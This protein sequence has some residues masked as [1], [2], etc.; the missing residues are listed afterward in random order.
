MTMRQA[1]NFKYI[2]TL[3]SLVIALNVVPAAA[4][5]NKKAKKP[6]T[7]AVVKKNTAKAP[8][9]QVVKPTAT[10]QKAS[11][12]NLGEAAA[13][14]A[15]DTAK[16]NANANNPGNLSEEIVVTTAYKPV[17]AD[18][19]KIRLN[20]DL[21]DKTPFK[22]PLTYFPI[23]KRLELNSG[24]K[25]LE[26]MKRPSERDTDI[27][28]NYIKAG[29]GNLKTTYAE[30]Y[31]ANSHDEALQVGGFLKHFAQNGTL[32]NQN[33]Q[34]DAVGAYIKTIGKDVS[35]T[36]RLNYNYNSNYFYGYDL[37]NPPTVLQ[38]NKQHFNTIGGELEL[39]KNFKDVDN[40]FTYALKLKGYS[41]SNA[42]QAKETNIVLSGFLNQTIGNFYA[43]LSGSVDLSTQ[44]DSL[45]DINN[46]LL[47]LNPYIK[48]QGDFYKIDLG[49]NIVDQL[50]TTS[51]FYIF[52]AAKV[53]LQVIPKYLRLFIEA[54]GDVNKTSLYDFSIVN[55]FLGKDINITNSVDQL[56]ISAG[57]KG[58]IAAGLGFKVFVF[59]NSVKNMPLFV[60][61]FNFATGYNRFNVIYDPGSSRVNGFNGE[62][63]LK[64]SADLDIFGRVEFKDYQMATVA[65]PWNLPKFKL[66][67][68]AIIRVSDKVSI[69]GSL[70]IR[71]SA[72]DRFS[73]T[74][75]VLTPTTVSSFTD[76]SA[77]FDYKVTKR[78]SI[79]VHANNLLNGTNQT[80]LYYPDYG[81][82]IFGGI[83]FSF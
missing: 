37:F 60:S 5:T 36:G 43:G 65:Q 50:G 67:A 82:N 30:A 58:T 18:A 53:E 44:Q 10:Q 79:F 28:N 26:A 9:K 47:R 27:T 35:F 63:D 8:V 40:D 61:N 66:T 2:C 6:A 48:L 49:I 38:V 20:P 15:A 74:T 70:V 11:A 14:A 56:D 72:L 7:N 19:V 81:F 45:Y 3:L 80:W 57:L 23:D 64:A 71:G 62:L 22:A 59:R 12:K 17:L 78:F 73:S 83:G 29:I 75:G 46:S 39:T 25:P 68:G 76:I 1:I 52:P 31:F 55:P 34:S 69:N 24:I 51:N 16:R 21:S 54:K 42:F 32:F 41:F 77:G 13:K 33:S 4:Q